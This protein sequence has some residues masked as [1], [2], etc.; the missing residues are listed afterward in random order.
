MSRTFAGLIVGLAFWLGLVLGVGLTFVSVI[1]P[2][3]QELANLHGPSPF[4]RGFQ[5]AQV[6]GL[7]PAVPASIREIGRDTIG[8]DSS[9]WGVVY[10]LD[11]EVPQAE[12]AALLGSMSAA[13]RVEVGNRTNGLK[14]WNLEESDPRTG[15]PQWIGWCT[16]SAGKRNGT[17][18]VF[19]STDDRRIV[20]LMAIHER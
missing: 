19:G 6:L 3:R 12:Q 18:T 9:T 20:L 4:L 10:R 17:I 2:R 8:P 16:Y 1:L 5:P 13:L 14:Y 11:L 7:D 15:L